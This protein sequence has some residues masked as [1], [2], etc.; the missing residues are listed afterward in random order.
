MKRFMV[1]FV[2]LGMVL[3]GTV[4]AQDYT[5]GETF[6]NEKGYADHYCKGIREYSLPDRS[7]VDC[8]MPHEA[9]EYDWGHKWYEAIGQSLWYAMNTGR[10]AG[11]VLII[12]ERRDVAAAQRC[13]DAI[14]HY[15]LPITLHIIDVYVDPRG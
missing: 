3:P 7:R 12:K 11:I 1:V 15:G 2:V 6:S 14:K 5:S 9:Q 13:A 4:F 8:L 10:P